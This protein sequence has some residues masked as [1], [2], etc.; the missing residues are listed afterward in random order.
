MTHVLEIDGLTKGFSLH[1]LEKDIAAFKDISFSV[2]AGEFVLLK[3]T[4]G[5]GKSTLLRTLYRS[6]LPLAGEIRFHSSHGMID[7]CCA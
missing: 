6:Y 2:A 1:H 5:A 4:N 7:A 3:G